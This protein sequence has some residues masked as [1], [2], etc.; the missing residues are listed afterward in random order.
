MTTSTV[1]L[2]QVAPYLIAFAALVVLYLIYWKLTSNPHISEIYVGAAGIPSATKLQ[3]FLWTAIAI[4]A[5]VAMY[6]A[7][8]QTGK[9]DPINEIP[10]NLLL[11]MGFSIGTN[12]GSR[13]IQTSQ[14]ANGKKSTSP[15]RAKSI[16]ED[17]DGNPDLSRIQMLAWTF[18]AIGVYFVHLAQQI[19]SGNYNTLPDIDASLMVL[20][21]L[22]Q[23]AFLGKQLITADTPILNRVKPDSAKPGDIIT[24]SG[25]SFGDALGGNVL[26]FDD[27]PVTPQ[28]TDWKDKEIQFSVPAKRPDGQDWPTAGEKVMVNVIVGGRRGLSPQSLTISK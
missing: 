24:L 27:D 23:G 6:V 3:W 17:D 5:Y 4:F 11:A 18:V 8:V 15:S 12:I 22:G 9:I 14:T 7:R 20:M 10:V 16:F 21:G 19:Q 28:V 26:L 1:T 25:Q 2:P 13:A